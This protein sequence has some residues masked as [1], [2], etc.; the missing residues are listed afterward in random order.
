MSSK[1]RESLKRGSLS[2]HYVFSLSTP[3]V[4][5][6]KRIL[7]LFWLPASVRLFLLFL[8]LSFADLTDRSPDAD[9][10][11]SWE[12]LIDRGLRNSLAFS[13]TFLFLCQRT[14]VT[15]LHGPAFLV[16]FETNS[17]QKRF[18]FFFMICVNC[19]AAKSAVTCSGCRIM[20][21]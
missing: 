2:F 18:S 10:C 6:I 20:I 12:Q 16:F 17:F 5:W 3:T 21:L 15:S 11:P 8:V 14:D 9:N 13:Q 19:S 4:K 7:C 1:E